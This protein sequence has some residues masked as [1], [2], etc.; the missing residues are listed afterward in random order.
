MLLMSTHTS[1]NC[2]HSLFKLLSVWYFVW[3][4]LFFPWFW[5]GSCLSF[6]CLCLIFWLDYKTKSEFISP[7]P[8]SVRSPWWVCTCRLSLCVP[9]TVLWSNYLER[10]RN[11]REHLTF[12]SLSAHRPGE[13]STNTCNWDKH[14]HTEYSN[15]T[16]KVDLQQL[17]EQF[18][19]TW[20]QKILNASCHCGPNCLMA[21]SYW[22]KW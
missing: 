12:K 15:D 8:L 3:F 18:R 19:Y 20:L 9:W 10:Q 4:C 16:Y 11:E 5:L 22:S 21:Q 2:F 6:C 17:F 13:E 7:L 1:V 14:T